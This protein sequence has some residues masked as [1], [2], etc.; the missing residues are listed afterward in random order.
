[1]ADWIERLN[2]FIDALQSDRRPDRGIAD[3]PDEIDELRFAA[4]LAGSRPESPV[5][6]PDFLRNLRNELELGPRSARR[7]K[8]SRAGLLRAAGLFVAGLA[9]GFGLNA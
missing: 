5:P 9:S 3:S 8:I 7:T 4:R 1:M 2:N 6:D